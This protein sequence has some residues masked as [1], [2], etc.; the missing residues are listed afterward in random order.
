MG[1]LKNTRYFV[2]TRLNGS[3]LTSW[4]VSIVQHSALDVITCRG[5]FC[6]VAEVDGKA[7]DEQNPRQA[8]VVT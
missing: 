1:R 3:P 7:N 5:L 8:F 6:S 4:V 2:L